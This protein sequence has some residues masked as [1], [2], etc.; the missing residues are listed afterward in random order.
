[1]RPRR[2][3][4]RPLRRSRR[5]GAAGPIRAVRCR[6]SS[7]RSTPKS[8]PI[9]VEAVGTVQA[10]ASVQLKSRIDSQIM[11]VNVEEGA[12]VKEGDLLFE[13][14]SRT[15]ARP[16]RPDRGADPQGPGADR[17]GQARLLARRRSADQGRRHGGDARHQRDDAEGARGAAR[18]PTRRCARTSWPSSAT[19]RSARR[20]RAA[21]ARSPTRPARSLRV[22][23]NTATAVLATINQVDPIFVHVRHAAGHPAGP[24]RGDGQGRGQGQRGDRRQAHASRAR[25]PSSR[26]PSI[27]TTGTVTAKARIANANEGLWPG[28]FVKAEVVLGIEP[29]AL[30]VPA[31]AVQLG[32]QGPY[33]FVDQGRQDRRGPADHDQ[34]HAGRRIG[35]RQR[36]ARPANQVV[37]DGQ[38]RLVNGAPVASS[39]PQIEA[40]KPAPAARLREA[41]PMG[42]SALCIRRPVMTILVMASFVIAGIFGFKQLPGRRRAARRLPDHPGLRRSCPAP[43]PRRWRRRSPRSSSASSRPSPA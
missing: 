1:M 39:P 32:P 42:I 28:Q 22:A 13:L 8:M 19:P 25:W 36:P 7:R 43:A 26:T 30:S 24:A 16:A 31:A 6:S 23:D 17:P 33:V 20:C 37:I 35:D 18:S 10:I 12:L 14:D 21:S 3:R 34:A 11:K 2:R 41:R 38:L 40:P 15:P 4:V 29:E 5:A 27:P 9:I